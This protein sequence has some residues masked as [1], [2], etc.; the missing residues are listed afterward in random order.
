ML[1]VMFGAIMVAFWIFFYYGGPLSGWFGPLSFDSS[2]LPIV[3]LYAGYIPIFV[4]MMKKEKNLHPVKRYV[5]PVLAILSCLFIVGA[6]VAS[7]GVDVLWYLLVFAVIMA[8]GLLLRGQ[9]KRK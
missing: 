5:M 9:K 7:H 3:T 1:S 6:A 2:E 4:M 8:I